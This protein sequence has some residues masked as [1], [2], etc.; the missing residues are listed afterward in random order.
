MSLCHRELLSKCCPKKI[1]FL[2]KSEMEYRMTN[3]DAPYELVTPANPGSEP[4]TGA[5]VQNLSNGL[6]SPS[7]VSPSVMRLGVE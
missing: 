3:G 2:D 4:G 7:A 1:S 5:G 6:D